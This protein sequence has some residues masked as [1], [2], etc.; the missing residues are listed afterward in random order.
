[1]GGNTRTLCPEVA[2]MDQSRTTVDDQAVVGANTPRMGAMGSE[3]S[4]CLVAV[5][6]VRAA[7]R[8]SSAHHDPHRALCRIMRQYCFFSLRLAFF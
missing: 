4:F 2:Q 6:A 3:E 1:M 5:P 7:E 8:L